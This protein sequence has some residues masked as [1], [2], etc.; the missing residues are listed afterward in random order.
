MEQARF[1]L[2]VT[3]NPLYWLCQALF[4]VGIRVY[5]RTIRAKRLRTLPKN[6][7]L[8]LAINHTNA[9]LDS[10]V[11]HI[12]MR[13]NVYSLARGD[14]FKNPVANY[15]LRI[16]H[17]L[18][19]FR[20]RE[21]MEHLPKNNESF[22]LSMEVLE[23]ADQP[24][25]IYPEGDC[26]QEYAIRPFRKG[27]ARIAFLLE[28][29]HN[30]ESGLEIVPVSLFYSRL[31]RWGG[32]LEVQVGKPIKVSQYQEAWQ[33]DKARAL[34]ALTRD[35][36]AALRHAGVHL[37]DA[38]DQALLSLWYEAMGSTATAQPVAHWLKKLENDREPHTQKDHLEAL[39]A[40][41]HALD[42][43][44]LRHPQVL[45]PVPLGQWAFSG[46]LALLGAA[47][48]LL[49]WLFFYLPFQWPAK[50]ARALCASVEF[51][52]SVTVGL[53]SFVMAGW[54]VATALLLSTLLGGLSFWAY[55]ALLFIWGAFTLSW[56][57]V[58]RRWY[59]LSLWLWLTRNRPDEARTVLELQRK[60]QGTWL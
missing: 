4:Q 5:F 9:F 47:P 55:L 56:G 19:I 2:N 22:R 43:H 50:K 11:L 13:R 3:L 53:C 25:I 52:A 29:K 33:H 38:Q 26:V 48:G 20:L 21:G 17:I 39:R 15:F 51:V 7:P 12:L 24:L 58:A 32:A 37:P 40:Y 14:V 41:H 28:E 1:R 45:Q 35:C 30:F 59:R 16:F 57:V 60:A 23:Q 42:Q 8:L 31:S 36:E 49:G 46:L 34:N 44:G 54:L 6:K 18:P 10:S 27:M